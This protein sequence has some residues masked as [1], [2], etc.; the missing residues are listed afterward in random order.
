LRATVHNQARKLFFGSYSNA[1][2]F[3]RRMTKTSWT[4]PVNW[5]SIASAAFEAKLLQ[6]AGKR[7][8]KGMD[9]MV[10]RLKAAAELEANQD[11][12]EGQQWG[13]KW[14]GVPTTLPELELLNLAF[15]S[16]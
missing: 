13:E 9:D 1:G 12:Q 5:S 3:F 2:S 11:Y 16:C 10:A 4:A 15:L 6:L 7:E 8:V 14:G